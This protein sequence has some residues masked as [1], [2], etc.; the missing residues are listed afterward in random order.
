MG[1]LNV[2]PDSF[3]P[4]S[5]RLEPGAAVGRALAMIAE[6]AELLDIGAESTRPGAGPVPGALEQERLLPVLE[7]LRGATDVPLSVD[8]RRASTARMAIEAGA[9]VINDIGAGRDP[10]MLPLLGRCGVGVVLMHMQGEPGTMQHD[11]RYDD[12]VAE[13]REWLDD[14]VASA[15]AAG[16]DTSRMVVDPGLGFGKLL[17]HN[18]ALLASLRRVAGDRLLLVGA[19]RK[20]FIGAI[21]G[22]DID[23]RLPGSL[24]ALATAR[25][26]GAAVVRVH[27][28]AA[29]VQFLDVLAAIADAGETAPDQSVIEQSPGS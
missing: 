24:A 1:I 18:L 27:D 15:T 9:D 3:Y 17:P 4:D 8:T 29:S 12:P 20:S 2:T 13:V 16:I 10:E 19:S 28:V 23:D 6:G 5:R 7:G 25:A 11:P 21:T 26:A 14:R 22:A